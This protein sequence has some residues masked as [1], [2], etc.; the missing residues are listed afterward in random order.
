MSVPP[1]SVQ[2]SKLNIILTCSQAP[3]GAVFREIYNVQSR[4]IIGDYNYGP[5]FRLNEK[6]R[7]DKDKAEGLGPA[8]NRL[9]DIQRWSDITWAVWAE[10]ARQLR[11]HND[12]KYIFKHDIRTTSTKGIMEL[13]GLPDDDDDDLSD[14]DDIDESF[15]KEWPGIKY[16]PGQ[17]EFQALLGTPHGK[18]IVWMLVDHPDEL[19][20]KTIESIT[21]FTAGVDGNYNL[22]FT[23]TG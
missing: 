13:A 12:L 23:L 20:G 11:A 8:E 9:P 19:D 14:D 7:A 16:V 2:E 6:P 3:T 10:L 4:T 5:L 18:G 17:D 15:D 1:K 21:M 22:L